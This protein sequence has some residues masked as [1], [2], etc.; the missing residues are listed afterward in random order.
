MPIRECAS[1]LRWTEGPVWLPDGSVL[2]VEIEG[3]TLARVYPDGAVRRIAHPGGGPNGAAIGPDGACYVCNAGGDRWVEHGGMRL[4]VFDPAAYSGGR[5]ER[6]DIGTGRVEV[7]YDACDGH[8]LCAPND[9]VF[10][11]AG[12]FWFT[13]MG[14]QRGRQ[15][16]VGAIYYARADGSLIREMLFPVASPN[17][18]ALS[19]DDRTLYFT[20]TFTGRLWHYPLAGPGEL[21]LPPA[22]F[23]ATRLLYSAPRLQLFDSMAV[24][25]RGYLHIACLME[26]GIAVVSPGG[27]LESFLPLP[28]PI[29]TNICF[30]GA[31]RRTAFVTLASH[32]KLVAF[33]ATHAGHPLHFNRY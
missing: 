6:V 8:P 29:T 2:V 3:G 9:L 14:K 11:A 28:D 10:D 21:A 20:E 22:P 30:G 33:D 25:E 18:I 12:G 23:D 27:E 16:D 19:P 7:L 1:G 15:Q 26:S 32:G 17:G 4:P 5:I 13:D 31:D 24:D